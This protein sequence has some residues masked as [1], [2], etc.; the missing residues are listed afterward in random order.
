MYTK[1]LDLIDFH[2]YVIMLYS[3]TSLQVSMRINIVIDNALM[4]EALRL[5]HKTKK[6]AVAEG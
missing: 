3:P 1:I 4:N 2:A 6:E 5:F